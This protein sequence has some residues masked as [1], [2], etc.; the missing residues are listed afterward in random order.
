[1]RQ[2]VDK[3]KRGH[4]EVDCSTLGDWS[5]VGA[6]SEAGAEGSVGFDSATGAEE[7]GVDSGADIMGKGRNELGYV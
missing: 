6:G 5:V 1:V 3:G 7:A 4:T 2:V